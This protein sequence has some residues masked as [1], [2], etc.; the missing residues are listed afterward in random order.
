MDM[1]QDMQVWLRPIDFTGNALNSSM[2]AVLTRMSIFLSDNRRLFSDLF[3]YQSIYDSI[4]RLLRVSVDVYPGNLKEYAKIK[5]GT[6][7]MDRLEYNHAIFHN[8][9]R[10]DLL[11]IESWLHTPI[12]WCLPVIVQENSD[13]MRILN[14][15]NELKDHNWLSIYIVSDVDIKRHFSY[16]TNVKFLDEAE[17]TASNFVNDFLNRLSALDLSLLPDPIKKIKNEWELGSNLLRQLK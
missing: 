17:F 2:C 13:L 5:F 15:S 10:T 16:T 6:R 1:V 8:T 11:D 3:T 12:E 4:N 9:L 7:R 14:F